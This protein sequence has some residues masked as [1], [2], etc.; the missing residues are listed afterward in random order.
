MRKRILPGLAAAAVRAR[1]T[2]S[3]WAALAPVRDALERAVLALHP[4]AVVHGQGALRAPNVT[5]VALP[6]WSGAELVAIVAFV[7]CPAA[8]P[9]DRLRGSSDTSLRSSGSL[10]PMRLGDGDSRPANRIG[11]S[12][13][14]NLMRS[15]STDDR[16]LSLAPSS[17][18]LP[19]CPSSSSS[20][21][22]TW[23]SA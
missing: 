7:A 16:E 20:S 8:A 18:P 3:A 1:T 14:S 22:L 17:F 9:P 12:V 13:R 10:F 23:P 4:T 19:S 21:S 15:S 6:P 5:N 11:L 2:R